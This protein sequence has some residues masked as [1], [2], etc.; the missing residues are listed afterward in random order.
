M[1]ISRDHFVIFSKYLVRAESV[2][3]FVVSE[4][5]GMDDGCNT[6]ITMFWKPGAVGKPICAEV[7]Y[8]MQNISQSASPGKRMLRHDINVLS[9]CVIERCKGGIG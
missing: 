8:H 4:E 3:S 6:I 2:F 7:S 5:L 9:L 1:G